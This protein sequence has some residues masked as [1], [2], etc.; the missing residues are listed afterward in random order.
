MNY[1]ITAAGNGSRFLQEGIKPPKPLIYALGEEL[2][3]KSLHSFPFVAGDKV[4][5]VTQKTQN[6][7][8]SISKKLTRVFPSVSI[9]WLELDFLPY[10]QLLSAFE[11]V[12][13]FPIDGPFLI[14]NC[15][16][17]FDFDPS[18]IEHILSIHSCCYSVVPVFSAPGDHWS[19]VRT[20][21]TNDS[22][23]VELSEKVRI[24]SHCSIGA[25]YFASSSDFLRDVR[26][27]LEHS[28][29]SSE[30]YVAPFIDYMIRSASKEV[31][32]MPAPNYK[33]YGTPSELCATFSL[34]RFELLAQNSWHAH[35]RKTLV[36]DIDG[37]LCGPPVN[38]DYSSCEPFCD[39]VDKLR[40]HHRMGHY[41]ILFTARNM[42]TFSGNIG[43]INKFTAPVLL[44]WLIQH[45]V[46]YDEIIF[47]KP[48]G[49]GGVEYL[50]DRCLSVDDFI[51]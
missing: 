36:V 31:F 12:K 3:I 20:D 2:L 10:G 27:Y 41:I 37:T 25:Y 22:K 51:S 1:I 32:I 18:H 17:S 9:F 29:V 33:L 38:G 50:D 43:L 23:A 47:N 48:W 11:A 16:T 21:E 34:S 6:I 49:A 42:R 15:D 24:S 14:H 35:Q 19:F 5:I 13:S 40:Q 7:R 45:D 46:P 39:V 28:N 8:S 44:H 4:F 26:Y 30:Y